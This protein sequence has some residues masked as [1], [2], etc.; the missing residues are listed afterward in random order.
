MTNTEETTDLQTTN[1]EEVDQKTGIPIRSMVNL[2]RVVIGRGIVVGRVEVE[3]DGVVDPVEV[4]VDPVE[5]VVSRV[6][7]VVIVQHLTDNDGH[8]D[9]KHLT[10]TETNHYHYQII[11]THTTFSNY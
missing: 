11:S 3:V 4:V 7:T 6:A 9:I 10:D 1:T 5:V 8:T 2:Y